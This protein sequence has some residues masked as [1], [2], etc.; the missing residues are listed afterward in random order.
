M[1]LD[2]PH[3]CG[4]LFELANILKVLP[5]LLSNYLPKSTTY[6]C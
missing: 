1:S 6:V 2:K 4:L 3:P 5:A